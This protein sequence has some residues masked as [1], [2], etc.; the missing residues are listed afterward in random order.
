MITQD[1]KILLTEV[2]VERL[3][4]VVL[5]DKTKKDI[6][7]GYFDLQQ[8]TPPSHIAVNMLFDSTYEYLRESDDEVL[9]VQDIPIILHLGLMKSTIIIKHENGTITISDAENKPLDN[10]IGM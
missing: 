6:V 8:Y 3:R 4:S 10:Y 7:Y 1:V 2:A 5:V 9:L